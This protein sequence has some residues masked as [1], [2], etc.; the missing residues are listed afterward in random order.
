MSKLE[1]NVNEIL[2]VENKTP[3]VQR[4]FSSTPVPRE[5]DK[6]TDVDNDYKYS[7]ENYYNLVE[8][9]QEAIPEAY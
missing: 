7:R 4:E 1:D 2:G 9:G 6:D 8:K 5:E 3:V